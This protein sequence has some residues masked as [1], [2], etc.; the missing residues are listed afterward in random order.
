MK[1][2][3]LYSKI[4]FTIYDEFL[5]WYKS[6]SGSIETSAHTIKY[7][8]APVINIPKTPPKSLF[9]GLSSVI[10]SKKSINPTISLNAIETTMNATAKI[11]IYDIP[12]TM[13]CEI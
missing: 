7:H 3:N 8:I 10:F 13:L 9:N 12:M 1:V 4:I 11:I 5:V 6:S 2:S